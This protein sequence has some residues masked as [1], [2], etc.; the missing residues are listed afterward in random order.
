M[1]NNIKHENIYT[2]QGQM[3]G[4]ADIKI[5]KQ[6]ADIRNIVMGTLSQKSTDSNNKCIK[7]PVK[8]T[9]I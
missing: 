6:P 4:C 8:A 2:D 9:Q 7:N 3:L 1:N 5:L